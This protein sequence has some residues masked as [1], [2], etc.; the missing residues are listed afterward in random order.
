MFK[1]FQRLCSTT[2]GWTLDSTVKETNILSIRSLK[3]QT[4]LQFPLVWLRD[5]CLCPNC[6]NKTSKSR[7][8]DLRTNLK[9][10][11]LHVQL[12]QLTGNIHVEQPSG[13][14]DL[15]R[16]DQT[17]DITRA[18]TT[19]SIVYS[20]IIY[21]N[22]VQNTSYNTEYNE[23]KHNAHGSRTETDTEID[24]EDLSVA[25]E[26][27]SYKLNIQWEDGHESD[28]TLDWLLT[29]NFSDDNR[30]KLSEVYK[31]TQIP[32]V[33]DEFESICSRFDYDDI[34]RNKKSLLRWMECLATYGVAIVENAGTQIGSLKEL[35]SKVGFLKKTQYGETFRV[36]A[37]PG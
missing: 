10:K 9:V 16:K 32:W 5:N 12:E 8:L 33:S 35:A 26:T 29:R 34:I 30:R 37:K 11:P 27:V 15:Q 21:S 36:E 13:N 18:T 22:E 23:S 1:T 14:I 19:K 4:K 25:N 20:K 24:K 31:M 28:F 17:T 2:K 7:I 3:D 6:F